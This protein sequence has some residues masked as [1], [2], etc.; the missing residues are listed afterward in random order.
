M[1]NCQAVFWTFLFQV[2]SQGIFENQGDLGAT[3]MV[4]KAES[5]PKIKPVTFLEFA[6]LFLALGLARPNI[7]GGISTFPPKKYEFH[8]VLAHVQFHSNVKDYSMVLEV[9]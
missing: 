4:L 2:T 3:I 1:I 8:S 9:I 7:R 5:G 6:G